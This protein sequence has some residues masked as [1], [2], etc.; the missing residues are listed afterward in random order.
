MPPAAMLK[1]SNE[2]WRKSWKL[3]PSTGRLASSPWRLLFKEPGCWRRFFHE[4]LVVQIGF[5]LFHFNS[6]NNWVGFH[7]LRK[8]TRVLVHCLFGSTWIYP[9]TQDAIVTRMAL[10]FLG[11]GIPTYI[12]L[13][14]PTGYWVEGRSKICQHDWISET[15]EGNKDLKKKNNQLM[16]HWWFGARWFGFLGSPYP[17]LRIPNHQWV[18]G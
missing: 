1:G 10:P 16:I 12:N 4:V 15:P 18:R 2:T 3:G 7:P 9:P 14:L 13:Y 8:Q 11:S 5:L 17:T 6:L